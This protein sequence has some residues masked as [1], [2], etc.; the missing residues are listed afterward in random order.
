[1]DII[2][3][4]GLNMTIA[5][6]FVIFLVTYVFLSNLVF[7]P[8]FKAYQ[9]RKKRTVGNEET[10][11]R[12]ISETQELEKT[13]EKKARKINDE[14]KA[15]YDSA[16]S[17]AMREHDQIVSEARAHAQQ[18]LSKA[19]TELKA[20]ADSAHSQIVTEA[21]SV[22]KVMVSKLLGKDVTT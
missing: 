15:M 4:L 20:Q 7:K 1:M 17:V 2:T 13:Y 3:S 21:P 12:V 18:L 14:F 10:A 19:R 9:E 16:R 6:Q 11:H 5:S 8:Y 22:A